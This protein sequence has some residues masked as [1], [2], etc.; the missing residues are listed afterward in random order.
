MKHVKTFSGLL[1][2]LLC[3]LCISCKKSVAVDLPIDKITSDRVFEN[4][5]TA[6]GAVS[7]IYSQMMPT[8]L[9]YSSGGTSIYAGLAADE[10]YI[11]NAT[12]PNEMQ[13]AENS[14]SASNGIIQTNFWY[15]SYKM[16]YQASLCI[17]QLSKSQT[18]SPEVK[19]TLLG[20]ARFIR[21]FNYFYLVNFF[22][23]VPLVTGTDYKSN[24]LI[25]R[26]PVQQV[27]QQIIEDLLAAKSL[28]PEGYSGQGKGRPNKWSA[29]ALLARVYLYMQ[30]WPNAA[31]EATAVLNSGAY[32]L[33]D[34]LNNVFLVS[35]KEAIWQLFPVEA[36]FNTTIARY[37]VPTSSATS[38]PAFAI[39][40]QLISSFLPGDK[41][42]AAWIKTKTV[43]GVQYNYVFKYKVRN[44]NLPVTEAY[45][46]LRL[47]EM[48]LIRAE[49]KAQM[50][51][52][53]EA[54]EDLDKI[55]FRAGLAESVANDKSSLLDEI[56]TERKRELFAEWGHRW[57]DLKRMG[58]AIPVLSAY[59]NIEPYSLLWP[60]P[61]SE[62]LRNP[63]L[64]QSPGY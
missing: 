46:V 5:Q 58:T 60:I 22:G 52:L 24:A 10:L 43:A 1:G 45:T 49:A 54:K 44:L 55:K 17:E 14:L 4:D 34:D 41:R 56:V 19:N 2:A 42:K 35:S 7:G 63:N 27:Y 26:T 21:A 12:N 29:T 50:D 59:K 30:D 28:L 8:V 38:R 40:P 64:T 33:E 57:F 39:T 9:F 37:L 18:I 31:A 16:N 11:T 3:I 62:L 6:I 25:S 13:F 47:A 32:F 53:T 36:G 48:Y 23:D 61:Q 15:W 20:E 51:Q